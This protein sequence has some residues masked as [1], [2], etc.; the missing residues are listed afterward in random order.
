MNFAAVM[1]GLSFVFATGLIVAGVYELAGQGWAL[2]TGGFVFML[3]FGVLARGGAFD[4][5]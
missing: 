2:L 5:G 4:R 1:A 3:I